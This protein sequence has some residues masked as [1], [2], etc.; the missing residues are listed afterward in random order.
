MQTGMQSDPRTFALFLAT[1]GEQTE[2]AVQ[3]AQRELQARAD[4]FTHDALVW[5]LASAGRPDEAW[6]HMEKALAEGTSDARLY[7]HAGVLAAK[8]GRTTAAESWLT[9]ARG[10]QHMLLPSERQQ[11]AAASASLEAPDGAV[12][13]GPAVTEAISNNEEHLAKTSLANKNKEGKEK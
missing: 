10:L 5:A 13:A 7:T 1:R 9:K 12:S 6:P 8:L 2:L 4:I 3:L 11:L